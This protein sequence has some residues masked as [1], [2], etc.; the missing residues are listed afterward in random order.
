MPVFWL[1]KGPFLVK[2]SPFDE[3]FTLHYRPD[4]T[5]LTLPPTLPSWHNLLGTAFLTAPNWH[6]LPGVTF[7]TLPCWHRL[8]N[9]T[10]L[11]LPSQHYLPNTTCLQPPS[12]HC[13]NDAALLRKCCIV[14]ALVKCKKNMYFFLKLYTFLTLPSRH[15][16]PDTTLLTPPA[17]H[18]LP[19]TTLLTQPF[20]QHLPDTTF[21]TPTSWHNLLSPPLWHSAFLR[22]LSWRIIFRLP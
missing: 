5:P 19:V 11:T 3:F 9:A 16:L 22:I 6:N 14:L 13:P 15:N 21:L 17:W 12:W 2:L 4:T 18:S 20:C 10:F 8:P 1:K 7:L